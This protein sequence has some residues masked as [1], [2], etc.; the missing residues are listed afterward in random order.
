MVSLAEKKPP[1]ISLCC[2]N[3][4]VKA[5]TKILRRQFWPRLNDD[6]MVRASR[7]SNSDNPALVRRYGRHLRFE[8][9][10]GDACAQD[11][12]EVKTAFL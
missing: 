8:A 10:I 9:L 7:D 4:R 11:I 2:V 3:R 5:L 6:K 1:T 12:K